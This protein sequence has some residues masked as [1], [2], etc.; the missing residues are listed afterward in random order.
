M[1]TIVVTHKPGYQFKS[2]L[3]AV[4][5]Y[6]EQLNFSTSEAL[7]AIGRPPLTRMPLSFRKAIIRAGS[8]PAH[9]PETKIN[10]GS[11]LNGQ[12]IKLEKRELGRI[13]RF[14]ADHKT[15]SLRFKGCD[16]AGVLRSIHG[17]CFSGGIVINGAPQL[18]I[19]KQGEPK[20]SACLLSLE[21]GLNM[22]HLTAV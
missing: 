4:L 12:I 3:G 21:R 15:F 14:L 10:W 6:K 5:H 7:R 13:A 11:D 9:I 18:K 20:G 19:Y 17:D 2:T 22:L 8:Q 16:Q 1:K